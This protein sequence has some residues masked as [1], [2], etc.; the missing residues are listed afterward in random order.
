MT[1]AHRKKIPYLWCWC[2]MR[3]WIW[4]RV[5]VRRGV[6]RWIG[7]GRG[8]RR[9]IGIRVR[10]RRRIWARVSRGIWVPSRNRILSRLEL[11]G[12]QSLYGV[13]IWFGGWPDSMVLRATMRTFS[14]YVRVCLTVA[15]FSPYWANGMFVHFSKPRLWKKEGLTGFKL[16]ISW[17]LKGIWRI[18]I[19]SFSP[20]RF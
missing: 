3:S 20:S 11:I 6:R 2:R 14:P 5:G 1:W 4:V 15:I 19:F 16:L 7:I 8:V 10:V 13:G 12:M 9:W 17:F 18:S